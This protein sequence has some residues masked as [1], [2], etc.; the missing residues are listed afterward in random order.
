MKIGVLKER[1]NFL[2]KRVALS[3]TNLLQ[4]QKNFPFLE[5]KVESSEYR[6]FSDAEYQENGFEVVT[7]VSDCAILFGVKEVPVE[8][9]IANK[10]YFFFSH[11]SKKQPHNKKLLQA[12]LD[13]NIELVDYELVVDPQNNRLLG[14][15]RYAGIIGFYNAL[16]AFGLKFELYKLPDALNLKNYEEL[17]MRLKRLVLPPLKIVVTGNGNVA[18]GVKE[19]CSFLKI[20]E[21]NETDFLTKKYTQVVFTILEASQ[22]MQHKEGLEFNL[23]DFTQNPT[24]YISDFEKFTKVSDIFVAAHYQASKTPVILSQA[25]L[26]AHT[27][28]LKVVAD[29]SCDGN[30]T[31]ACSLRN[32]TNQDF[33]YGYLPN[34]NAEVEIHHPGAIVVMAIENLPAVLAAEAS[35]DFGEMLLEHLIPAYFGENTFILDNATIVKNGTLTTKFRYLNDFLMADAL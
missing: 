31:I 3:P 32:S 2:D 20:K 25:M 11:T 35:E 17:K 7:D 5:I 9:L 21:I 23:D 13:N 18:K 28:C 30:G 34:K 24:N 6:I 15:G 22:Y 29:I 1:K 27:N 10:K 12:I 16:R 8:H 26:A 33:V 4:L 14:F 19:I